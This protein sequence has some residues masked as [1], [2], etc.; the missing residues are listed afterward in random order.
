MPIIRLDYDSDKVSQ[1]EATALSEAAQKIV[2]EATGIEDVFVYGNSSE[3]KL[4]V[5]PVE[6][7]VEM[8]AQK[9]ADADKLIAE[10][11]SRLA[12]WKQQSKFPHPINLT[13]IPMQWKVEVGI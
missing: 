12:E 2:S 9:I 10:I 11:K 7:F 6:I 8:S 5:A 3:I 13:L 4:K 1:A